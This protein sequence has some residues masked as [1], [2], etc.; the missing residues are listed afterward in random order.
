MNNNQLKK[1]YSTSELIDFIVKNNEKIFDFFREYYSELIKEKNIYTKL[2]VFLKV[3][4][5]DKTY[6]YNSLDECQEFLKNN[7]IEDFRIYVCSCNKSISGKFLFSSFDLYILK[8]YKLIISYFDEI[9]HDVFVKYYEKINHILKGYVVFNHI[10]R[11]KN[12]V[13]SNN[14]DDYETA[15]RNYEQTIEEISK[16]N[17]DVD[18]LVNSIDKKV[19]ELDLESIGKIKTSIQYRISTITLFNYVFNNW[20]MLNQLLSYGQKVMKKFL[21]DEWNRIK[22]ELIKTDKYIIIDGE[23]E[24]TIDSF[25]VKINKTKMGTTVYFFS[26]PNYELNDNGLNDNVSKYVALALTINKPRYFTLEYSYKYF[27]DTPSWVVKEYYISDNKIAY[28][29]YENFDN[30]K[31]SL[32]EDYILNILDEYELRK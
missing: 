18:E 23:K 2:I 27:I 7:K 25:D 11:Y 5:I 21:F 4:N 12:Q 17:I 9:N 6:D 8:N 1:Q 31:L 3:N 20:Y 19:A 29:I 32:F 28:N 10:Y 16:R 26:F 24:V 15:L 14:S 30:D 13:D 22:S